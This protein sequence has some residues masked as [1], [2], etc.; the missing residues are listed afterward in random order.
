MESF[1][2]LRLWA[3]RYDKREGALK[4][5]DQNSP[6]RHGELLAILVGIFQL[7]FEVHGDHYEQPRANDGPDAGGDIPGDKRCNHGKVVAEGN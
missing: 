2:V 5:R 6:D 1:F 3:D 4:N 7:D